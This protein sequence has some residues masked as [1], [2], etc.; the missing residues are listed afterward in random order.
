MVILYSADCRYL[1][2]PQ[3]VKEVSDNV[4]PCCCYILYINIFLHY[5]II[6]NRCFLFTNL[7]SSA[8]KPQTLEPQDKDKIF[9]ASYL[10]WYVLFDPN[11]IVIF[12][13]KT[14]W[15]K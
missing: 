7:K 3:N 5:K 6:N 11:I 1:M 8:R 4:S 12:A 10:M 15:C 14:N 2:H 9:S 13:P